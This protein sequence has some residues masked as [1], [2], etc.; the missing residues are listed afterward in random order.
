[1]YLHRHLQKLT[2]KGIVC[3]VLVLLLSLILLTARSSAVRVTTAKGPQLRPELVL[4]RGHSLGVTCAAFAPNGNWIA[5]GA[6][7][8]TILIWQLPSGRQL[9]TLSG[10]RGPIRSVAIS[11]NGEL[12]ASGSNDRTIKIWNV[13]R[14]TEIFTLTGHA[15]SINSLSFSP[16]GEW[17]ASGGVDKTIRIWNV[18]TGK[19]VESLTEAAGPVDVIT[20]SRNG[21]YL[22]SSSG[23]DIRI[24]NVKT[25][26]SPH[27]FVRHSA[28]VTAI[29]FSNDDSVIASGSTDGTVWLWRP[30][31]D[32]EQFS[33]K[34]NSASVL[35]LSFGMELVAAHADG[36]LEFWNVSNGQKKSSSSVASDSQPTVFASF[37]NDASTLAFGIGE[38]KVIL[39]STSSGRVAGTLE[40]HSAAI[41][42]VS[43]SNDNKWF[44]AASND[45]SIRLWQLATGRELPRLLG[46]TGYVTT[47]AFSPD[48]QLIASGSRSGELKVWD[49]STGQLAFSLPTHSKSINILVFSPDGKSLAAAGMDHNI[50]IWDRETKQVRFLQGH[51]DEIT[52]LVF[53]DSGAKLISAGFDKTVRVWNCRTSEAISSFNNLDVEV[54]VLAISPNGKVLAAANADNTVRLWRVPDPTPIKTLTGHTGRVLAVS[55]NDDGTRLASGGEDHQVILWDVKTEQTGRQLKGNS[56]TVTGVAF[57]K[58]GRFIVSGS[59]DGS[60]SIWDSESAVLK[61]TIV[62][63]P[64]SDDWLVTTPD[65]LF[66]GSPE[67]WNLMLWR[68]DASTFNVLAV[69]SFFNEFYYPGVLADVLADKDP[70]APEDIAVKDRRQPRVNLKVGNGESTF[71]SRSIDIEVQVAGAPSD[72]DH[73]DESGA[74]DLRLFRN[75][76]LV[77][78]WTGDLLQN[79]NARTLRTT[80]QIVAGENRISAYAFNRDNIKSLEATVLVNGAD[81]LKRQGTANMLVIGVERYENPQYNL[82]YPVNDANAMGAQLQSEQEQLGKYNPIVTI[83]LTDAQATKKNILGALARLAGNKTEP[84][85]DDAPKILSSI[86]AAQPEDV[87]VIYFS[88][89]GLAVGDRFYLIP[90][91][92]G[93]KGSR[94]KLDAAAWKTILSHSISDEELVEA[95]T[96]LD[97]G[98]L[99][100]VIDACNSGQALESSERRRGPMNTKGLA[101]LAYEKGI[102][103]LT[104]SQSIEVAF[105]ADALK[106]SYLA[107]ALIEEGLKKRAADSNHDGNIFLQEWFEYANERVPQIRKTRYRGSKELVED[108]V[109]EQKVQ[110]PRVFYTRESGA[111]QFLVARHSN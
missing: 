46:H 103:V 97:A 8:N 67:S 15:G 31:S 66:D 1:M 89:H 64:N 63:M 60:I 107:Y 80:I 95:L 49:V 88:G 82:K 62:S 33:L 25:W 21:E 37:N 56:D 93:Y 98:Q 79:S 53:A 72:R 104:A 5:S 41:N 38:K 24:W 39:K 85:P 58:N 40:S 9:R 45:S 44:A 10:H 51:T 61:A 28:P 59:D 91:D 94:D 20:F 74:R 111:K 14:G 54:D 71:T 48:N 96:P 75:G 65:G 3:A 4:Q 43:F 84:L 26:R 27:K 69:E 100:V 50:E 11:R 110:R 101:Q 83:P 13:D 17:L 12:L 19:Q 87:V 102:Y 92:L 18:K 105:E 77:K 86:K 68:F 55:F 7:D 109:D 90:H 42:A 108:E 70:K 36:V 73:Q 57:T 32:R 35:A 52:S 99:L 22:A 6:A 2:A 16:N 47:L 78:T 23:K 106:H 81:N 34:S 29:A 30:N 76:L